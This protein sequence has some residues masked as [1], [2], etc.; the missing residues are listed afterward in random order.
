MK[1]PIIELL[2]LTAAITFLALGGIISALTILAV[3]S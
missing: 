1:P 2:E 3:L